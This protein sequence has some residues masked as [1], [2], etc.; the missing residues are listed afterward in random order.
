[1]PLGAGRTHLSAGQGPPQASGSPV[2][3]TMQTPSG[4]ENATVGGCCWQRLIWSNVEPVRGAWPPSAQPSWT[5]AARPVLVPARLSS[6]TA[7]ALAPLQRL[8]D[9]ACGCASAQ[10]Q[11][12]T[13]LVTEGSRQPWGPLGPR[14]SC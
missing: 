8:P 13:V 10:G 6:D 2:G 9:P 14:L 7:P 11:G 5:G 4:T 1:M 3:H 12:L